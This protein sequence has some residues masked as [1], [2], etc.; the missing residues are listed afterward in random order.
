[1]VFTVNNHNQSYIIKYGFIIINIGS[2]NILSLSI[3]VPYYLPLI[4]NP[5]NNN[6][7][8]GITICIDVITT[9]NQ[10]CIIPNIYNITHLI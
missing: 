10:Y 5:L 2:L 9:F 3:L 6:T 1:M 4:I 7:I 8:R